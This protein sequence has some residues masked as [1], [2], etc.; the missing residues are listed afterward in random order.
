[1]LAED[2]F[3]LDEQLLLNNIDS[4]LDNWMQMSDSRANVSGLA[5]PDVNIWSAEGFALFAREWAPHYIEA[6]TSGKSIRIDAGLLSSIPYMLPDTEAIP[7]DEAVSIANEAIVATEGWHKGLMEYFVPQA[8][9]RRYDTD[10]WRVGYRLYSQDFDKQLALVDRAKKGEIPYSTYVYID[11][12]TGEILGKKCK[13]ITLYLSSLVNQTMRK[14]ISQVQGIKKHL[15]DN[16]SPGNNRE[17][18]RR[19]SLPACI[20][21]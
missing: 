2:V 10:V 5:A 20:S 6:Y 17:T 9:Y 1:V 21:S 7:Q 8:S 11:A 13:Q 15:M 14:Y 16:Y 18:G 19:L 12:H 4:L 3:S